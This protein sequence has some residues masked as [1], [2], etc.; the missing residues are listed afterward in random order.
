VSPPLRWTDPPFNTKNF[1]DD[2][3]ASEG[4]RVHWLLYRVAG[5]LRDAIRRGSLP[6]F[7]QTDFYPVEMFHVE[8]LLLV[9][10]STMPLPSDLRGLIRGD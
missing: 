10:K 5:S 6:L 3:D 1:V 9:T 7:L 4:A 2:H 8:D